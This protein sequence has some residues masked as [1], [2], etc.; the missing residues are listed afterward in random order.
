MIRLQV[1]DWASG[2]QRR[3]HQ[4]P[5]T[6][7]DA[8]SIS[9]RKP[10]PDIDRNLIIPATSGMNFFGQRT[11]P[12]LKFANDQRVDV[13]VLRAVEKNPAADALRLRSE[14]SAATSF[15]PF[16]AAVKKIR[17]FP[18]A[19]AEGLRSSNIRVN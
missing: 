2:K 12:L 18:S 15:S 10:E 17:S 5:V 4:V 8:A 9:S 6:T 14:S 11:C 19:R 16:L 3:P 13:F 7:L 1:H